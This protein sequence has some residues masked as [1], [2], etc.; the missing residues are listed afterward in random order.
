MSDRE[1]TD[2]AS[3]TTLKARGMKRATAA[4]KQVVALKAGRKEARTAHASLVGFVAR[5]E[6]DVKEKGAVLQD[7][8]IRMGKVDREV[9]RGSAKLG[10]AHEQF[11]GLAEAAMESLCQLT[12]VLRQAQLLKKRSVFHS[13]R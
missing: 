10:E 2:A 7:T 1:K 4:V 9:Q 12:E 8:K 13:C 3:K 6:A 11:A 5:S